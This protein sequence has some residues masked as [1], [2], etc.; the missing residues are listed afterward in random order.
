MNKNLL[1]K[2]ISEFALDIDGIHGIK[3]WGRVCNHARTIAKINGADLEVVTLFAFLHDSKRLSEYSDIDHGYRAEYFVRS[4]NGTY[5]ELTATQLV[6]LTYAI[7]NHSAGYVSNDF[8]V[9][10]CWDADRLDLVR[11]GIHPN[12]ELLSDAAVPFIEKA[13]NLIK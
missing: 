6:R 9:Q 7:R 3:H 13:W 10:C 12:P 1:N 2:I 8:T 11:L 4:L 5:F